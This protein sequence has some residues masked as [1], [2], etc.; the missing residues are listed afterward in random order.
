MSHTNHNKFPTSRLFHVTNTAGKDYAS[1]TFLYRLKKVHLME[2]AN[3]AKNE[4]HHQNG[5]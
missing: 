5:H 3:V 4:A 1:E 2:T